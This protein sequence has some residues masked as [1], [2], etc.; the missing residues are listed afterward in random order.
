MAKNTA[1]E[2]LKRIKYDYLNK[3]KTGDGISK[4]YYADV[5]RYCLENPD[6]VLKHGREA[7]RGLAR[8]V[9]SE[10]LGKDQG[11][12]TDMH[13]NG[14]PMAGEIIYPIF[15]SEGKQ[16]FA[17]KLTYYC[18]V[19]EFRGSCMV[20]QKHANDAQASASEGWNQLS[21]L[22]DRANGDQNMLIRDLIDEMTGNTACPEDEA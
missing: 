18:A 8:P 19:R 20:V 21:I 11:S 16:S 10:K 3:K 5:D 13:L 14:E 4:E 22:E 1:I 12:Q 17:H 2:A 15:D 7:I 6:E 9:W